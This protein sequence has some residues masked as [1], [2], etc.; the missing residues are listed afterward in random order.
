LRIEIHDLSEENMDDALLACTP[1]RIKEHPLYRQGTE[2][3]RKW[4][5]NTYRTVGPCVKIAYVNNIPAGMIQYTPLHHVPY[6][7]TKKRD[8]LYI[9]CIY[10]KKEFRLMGVASRLLESLMKEMKQPNPVFENKPC[11]LL[12]TSARERYGSNQ[13]SYFRKKG[14][15]STI[16]NVDAGLTLWLFKPGSNECL[17]IPIVG[18]SEV[19]EK[20]VR[21]FFDPTCQWCIYLN[22]GV[23]RLIRELNP[24]TPIKETSLCDDPEE[25]LKRRITCRVTYVNGKP[26]FIGAAFPL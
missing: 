24:N 9:H 12:A 11:R 3:R 18:M 20:G 10:T 21:I 5:L 6:F 4:L 17:D 1:E 19:N 22:E 14:F 7:T 23:K 2:I 16:G 8:T 15:K 13:P 25:A 26:A